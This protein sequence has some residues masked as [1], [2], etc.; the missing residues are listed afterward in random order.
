M[1]EPY[2]DTYLSANS[3]LAFEPG[4]CP[5]DY[6]TLSSFHCGNFRFTFCSPTHCAVTYCG[7][8]YAIFS[9]R[10]TL[11]KHQKDLN[12]HGRRWSDSEADSVDEDDELCADRTVQLYHCPFTGC[13][14][15]FQSA[16]NSNRHRMVH[17]KPFVCTLKMV[18]MDGNHKTYGNI[19]TSGKR[20]CNKQFATSWDLKIH[21]RTHV[22]RAHT[23][24]PHA[25]LPHPH[26]P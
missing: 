18:Q 9:D 12:H 7:E 22:R 14:K 26:T 15:V 8:C 4:S 5:R 21:R 20:V 6:P 16:H 10:K 17:T 25:L 1:T 2:N 24:L 11:Y 3:V 19:E 13:G 23:L